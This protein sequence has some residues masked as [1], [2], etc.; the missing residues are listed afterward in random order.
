[1]HKACAS[2]LTNVAVLF[3]NE[4]GTV[5]SKPVLVTPAGR[6]TG[7]ALSN[8]LLAGGWRLEL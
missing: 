5:F 4:P 7:K 6:E 8:V 1:M 3:T 2:V